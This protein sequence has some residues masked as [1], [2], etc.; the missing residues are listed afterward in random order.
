MCKNRMI[1]FTRTIALVL[2]ITSFLFISKSYASDYYPKYLNNNPNFIL[3]D[4][5]MDG[6]IYYDKS[7]VVNVSYNPPYYKIAVNLVYV[8]QVTKGNTAISNVSTTYFTYD[9]DKRTVD[10]SFYVNKE[11][12]WYAFNDL[13]PGAAMYKVRGNLDAAELAFFQIYGLKFFNLKYL[14]YKTV[15]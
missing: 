15:L 4:G 7:S 8:P 12:R 10:V 2:A 6:G 3:T 1:S 14:D 5:H 13:K 9:Y 11:N